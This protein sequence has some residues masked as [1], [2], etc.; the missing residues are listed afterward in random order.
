MRRAT[1]FSNQFIFFAMN[2]LTRKLILVSL[3]LM[4]FIQL[5]AQPAPNPSG[6]PVPLDGGLTALL[7]AGAV[8]GIKK[9][10]NK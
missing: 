3:M 9:L 2:L 4:P 7:A 8:Y 1:F 5:F 6:Q 10:R